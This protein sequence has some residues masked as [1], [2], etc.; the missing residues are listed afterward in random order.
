MSLRRQVVYPLTDSKVFYENL[1]SKDGKIFE[2]NVI[3]TRPSYL[4]SEPQAKKCSPKCSSKSLILDKNN[5]EYVCG[6]HSCGNC[7]TVIV[8]RLF[9]RPSEITQSERDAVEIYYRDLEENETGNL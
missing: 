4:T 7:G 6:N 9:E 2:R 5:G 3:V 8:E 1:F